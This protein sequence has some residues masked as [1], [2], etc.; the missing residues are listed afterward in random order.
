MGSCGQL[1]ATQREW[2]TYQG[3]SVAGCAGWA[4]AFALPF[5]AR[6]MTANASFAAIF[7]LDLDV[8]DVAGFEMKRKLAGCLATANKTLLVGDHFLSLDCAS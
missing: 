3:R 2:Q 6:C 1:W 5:A 7:D 8:A 4:M